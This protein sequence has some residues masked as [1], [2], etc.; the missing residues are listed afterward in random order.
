MNHG[1][2]SSE[3][4]KMCSD[5]QVVS[6]L[7]LGTCNVGRAPFL[8]LHHLEGACE[9][10]MRRGC[11]VALGNEANFLQGEGAGQTALTGC[12]HC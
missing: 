7:G 12:Q 11:S 5:I 9:W 10:N 4:N 2:F 8:I 1:S 3:P 6:Q